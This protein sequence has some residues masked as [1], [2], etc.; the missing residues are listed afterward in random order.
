MPAC[1]WVSKALSGVC[2]YLQHDDARLWRVLESVGLKSAISDLDGGLSAKVVD[3]G[4]NFSLV[5]ETCTYTRT[6]THTNTHGHTPLV[7]T[8]NATRLCRGI[9]RSIAIRSISDC[10]CRRGAQLRGTL[11]CLTSM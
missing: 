8:V 7:E 2:V 11:F 9:V 1:I 6:G 3:N 10:W 5:S 4:N